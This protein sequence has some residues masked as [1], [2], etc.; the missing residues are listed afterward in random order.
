MTQQ[1]EINFC[2][3]R[4]NSKENQMILEGKKSVLNYQSKVIL[5]A[6]KRGAR[7]SVADGIKGI[8]DEDKGRTVFIGDA[9]ARLRDLR[10]AGY[11]IEWEKMPGGYRRHFLKV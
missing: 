3:T 6:L 11:N 5:A 8:Y 10:K 1:A 9:R 4:Q 2:T 7:L